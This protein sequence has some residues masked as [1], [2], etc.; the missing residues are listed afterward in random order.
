VSQI[1]RTGRDYPR[2]FAFSVGADRNTHSAAPESI[3]RIKQLPKPETSQTFNT[4]T[5][6]A[7][8]GNGYLV[9]LGVNNTSNFRPHWPL[10]KALPD[11]PFP[12]KAIR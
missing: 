6:A 2:V 1:E 7:R 10:V 4:S 9:S 12:H 3:R 8:E 5:F 11:S